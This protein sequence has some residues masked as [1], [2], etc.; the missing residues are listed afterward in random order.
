L[1]HLQNVSGGILSGDHLEMNVSVQTGARAQITTTGA[2][3]IYQ[4]READPPA[5]QF[6]R[7]EVGEG[8]ILEYLPDPLIPFAGARFR[9]ETRITLREGAGLFWWETV[10]PG[11]E[12]KGEVFE[13]DRLELRLDLGANEK[14][15]AAER[16]RLEPKRQPMESLARMGP[17]R[18]FTTF[19]LCV[20]E[21]GRN[22]L[23]LESDLND[24][25]AEM[26][27]PGELLWGASALP[28]HGLI[29]RGLSRNSRDLY[30]GLLRFWAAA[31]RELFGL[32]AVP[33]RKIY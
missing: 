24:I 18:Y 26:T 29:V 28:A 14:P 6:N 1:V 17:Y 7:A 20:V 5:C 23:A 10:A 12:A 9:Q 31:K 8:G 25:A 15:L 21:A 4:S 11:R 30:P 32:D 33:P 27:R 16:V 22:W 2:T 13:Y 19:Y 3:R